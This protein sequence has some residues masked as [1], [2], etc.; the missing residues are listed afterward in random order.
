M[1]KG[2]PYAHDALGTKASFDAT[3]GA[4]LKKFYDTWYVPNN[5]DIVI[6]GDVDPEAVL[7]QVKNYFGSIPAKPLPER[8]R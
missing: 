3:T 2:T 7:A 6:A 1:F 4:M 8:P 5:A